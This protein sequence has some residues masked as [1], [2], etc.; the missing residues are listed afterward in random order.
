MRR[1][2]RTWWTA[3]LWSLGLVGLSAGGVRAEGR[4][5]QSVRVFTPKVETEARRLFRFEAPHPLAGAG[6]RVESIQIAPQSI[7]FRV[8]GPSSVALVIRVWVRARCGPGARPPEGPFCLTLGAGGSLPMARGRLEQY[9]VTRLRARSAPLVAGLKRVNRVSPKGP[10]APPTLNIAL[11]ASVLGLCFGWYWLLA[12]GQGALVIGHPSRSTLARWRPPA[13]RLWLLMLAHGLL[14]VGFGLAVGAADGPVRA[15]MGT[16]FSTGLLRH[17]AALV[18]HQ[19]APFFAINLLAAWLAVVAANGLASEVA[20]EEAGLVAAG[21][22]AT[23]PWL[24]AALVDPRGAVVL[25]L[26][27]VVA[28]RHFWA[29]RLGKN[30]GLAAYGLTIAAGGLWQTEALL[31]PFGHAVAC[32]WIPPAHE[33][34]KRA[35]R[36]FVGVGLATALLVGL[37]TVLLGGVSGRGLMEVTRQAGGLDPRSLLLLAAPLSGLGFGVLLT[38][39]V[40]DPRRPAGLHALLVLLVVGMTTTLVLGSLLGPDLRRAV[41]LLAVGAASVG[42][43]AARIFTRPLAWSTTWVVLTVLLNVAIAATWILG[44]PADFWF[45]W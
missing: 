31:I 45:P 35:S 11:I 41:P 40:W 27:T 13:R 10:P 28:T 39:R 9:L 38:A 3:T 34:A 12:F 5:Q 33:Q 32:G 6:L 44:T 30:S 18:T 7:F 29:A 20:D 22:L 24:L 8:T 36:W 16:A 2:W 15:G 42:A 14:S 43:A 21:I 4:A 37:S 19:A 25:T 17:Q 26:A 23:S 1:R